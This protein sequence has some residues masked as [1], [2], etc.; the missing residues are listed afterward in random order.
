M[1]IL[2]LQIS[3]EQVVAPAKGAFRRGVGA[4]PQAVESL[5]DLAFVRVLDLVGDD[6]RGFVL[7]AHIREHATPD[8]D[9]SSRQRESALDAWV[10]IVVDPPRQL[11]IRVSAERICD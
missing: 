3:P 8:D 1:L 11:A 4:L 5:G 7:G 9:V 6:R 2:L 10:W